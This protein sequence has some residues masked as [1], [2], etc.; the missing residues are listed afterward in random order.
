MQ[1]ENKAALP[2]ACGAS[3]W[4]LIRNPKICEVIYSTISTEITQHCFDS[5]D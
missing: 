3:D 1:K 4:S 5:Q 2:N